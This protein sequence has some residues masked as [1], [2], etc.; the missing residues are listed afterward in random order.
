MPEIE[1]ILVLIKYVQN[2][3]YSLAGLRLWVIVNMIILMTNSFRKQYGLEN[4]LTEK[5]GCQ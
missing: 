1:F 5:V 4:W 2:K 3:K